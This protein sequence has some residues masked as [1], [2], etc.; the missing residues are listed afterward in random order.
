MTWGG[1]CCFRYPFLYLFR[2]Q[3]MRN[4]KFKE[5]REQVVESSR[6][7]PLAHRVRA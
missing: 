3:N 1:Y 5:L 6:C 7:D 4:D 2:F